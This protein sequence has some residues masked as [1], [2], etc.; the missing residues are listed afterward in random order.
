MS[1]V[2]LAELGRRLDRI[3]HILNEQD[4]Q[5]VGRREYDADWRAQADRDRAHHRRIE[6]LEGGQRW[7]LRGLAGAFLGLLVQAAVVV[8]TVLA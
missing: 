5:H 4:E 2:T 6:E 1:E 8:M 3:E 7:M